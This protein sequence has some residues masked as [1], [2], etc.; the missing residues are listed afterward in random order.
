[1]PVV[2]AVGVGAVNCAVAI[3]VPTVVAFA[4]G[5][6][7]PRVRMESSDAYLLVTIKVQLANE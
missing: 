2:R 3:V 7:V 6:S 5:L 4:T 1:M